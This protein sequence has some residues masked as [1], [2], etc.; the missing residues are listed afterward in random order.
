MKRKGLFFVVALVLMV[1]LFYTQPKWTE[2]EG[3]AKI[4]PERARR[5]AV[6]GMQLQVWAASIGQTERKTAEE[7]LRSGC[8]S[9]G[10]TLLPDPQAIKDRGIV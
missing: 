3:S 5:A 6:L 9:F 4:N 1:G 8:R 2:A 10:I 7:S